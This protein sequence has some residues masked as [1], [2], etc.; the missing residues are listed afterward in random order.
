M[1]KKSVVIAG[2]HETSISLE[3]AFYAE[4]VAIANKKNLSINQL[5]TK[6]DEERE[7]ENLSSAIRLYILNY[8]KEE[9]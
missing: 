7:V 9:K 6:I 3:D 1:A 4:L 2:R 8:L 5:V